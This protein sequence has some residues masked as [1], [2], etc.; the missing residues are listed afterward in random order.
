MP[1]ERKENIPL[2]AAAMLLGVCIL[3]VMDA[4]AKWLGALGIP[5]AQIVLARFAFQT[6]ALAGP[7]LW[8]A[9]R[10][11]RGLIPSRREA[12]GHLLRG[13]LIFV[14][15]MLFFGAIQRNPIP[16]ALAAFFIEPLIVFLLARKLLGERVSRRWVFAGL[17]GFV[18]VLIVLSPGLGRGGDYHWTIVCAPLA[19]FTFAGYMV[20]ARFASFHTPPLATAWLTGIAGVLFAAPGA[21]LFWVSPSAEGWGW[22]ALLGFFAATGHYFVIRAMA[23]ARASIVAPLQYAEIFA[24]AVINYF[25]FRHVPGPWMWVGFAVIAGAKLWAAAL[26]SREAKRGKSGGTNPSGG[27]EK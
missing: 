16:D 6:V 9:R 20:S 7:A 25:V 3:S 21:V 26:E 17:A 1:A 13:F 5:L 2:A 23:W 4:T 12:G 22:M 15:T 18:G 14:S 19:A 27:T 11:P 10:N 24:A 8:S